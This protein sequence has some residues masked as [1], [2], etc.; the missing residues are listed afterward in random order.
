MHRFVNTHIRV[1]QFIAVTALLLISCACDPVPTGPRKV[2]IVYSIGYNNLSSYLKEDI[3][4]LSES[5]ASM[6]GNNPVIIFSHSTKSYKAYDVPNSPVV[7]ELK[8]TKAGNVVRD[9]IMTMEPNTVSA[10]KETLNSFLSFVKDRYQD[11]EYNI[12]FSSHGT[13]WTPADYCNNPEE[14]DAGQNGSIWRSR[15]NTER[16]LPY[17]GVVPEDGGPV[18]KSFGVQNITSNTYHEMDI[19]DM[20]DAFPMKMKTII[21]DACFMGCVEVA[22]EFRDVTENMIAS[23]TEILADG[24][25]YTT[26]LSYI[27]KND[28]L[29][30]F[31]ENF[32]DFYNKQSGAYQS[33]TISLVDCT[34][35][36]PLAQ[37]CK[38]IFESQRLQIAGLEGSSDIQRYFRMEYSHIHKWFYDLEDIARHAGIS[39]EQKEALESAIEGCV[40]YKAATERFISDIT[41][42]N[43]SGLSMYLPYKDRTYLNNFYKTLDWN[44]ATGLVQ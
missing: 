11:A 30:G 1:I 32:F 40:R 2:F 13:G 22:Y 33:A 12:L 15:R 26:M 10:S 37:A 25:D 3:N 29:K 38:D 44:K 16:P 28:D 21:F 43:H 35:L 6:T 9:T 17:W 31:C 5:Y 36:E 4:E 20:A 27:L 8:K 39:D 18:V 34:R 14:Y 24:M 42:T 41:I 7:I 23:Q 19:T